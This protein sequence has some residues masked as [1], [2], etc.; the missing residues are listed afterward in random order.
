MSSK[1]PKKTKKTKAVLDKDGL[2]CDCINTKY[3]DDLLNIYGLTI[4]IVEKHVEQVN[5]EI[6]NALTH[7]SRARN[8]KSKKAFKEEIKRAEGHFERAKKDC[9]KVCILELHKRLMRSIYLVE[10]SQGT[11]K[12]D[13]KLRLRTLE[14]ERKDAFIKEGKNDSK[15][16]TDLLEKITYDLLDLEDQ[17]TTTYPKAFTALGKINFAIVWL[18][19]HTRKITYA[20]AIAIIANQIAALWDYS[21]LDIIEKFR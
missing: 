2:I 7:L 20:I 21:I 11:I 6:R 13:I 1:A 8:A 16:S 5:N 19:V 10:F 14:K 3:Y 9:L 17:I 15:G 4:S 12:S 18:W